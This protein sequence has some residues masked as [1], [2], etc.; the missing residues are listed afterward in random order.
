MQRQQA[1]KY[2]TD[3]EYEYFLPQVGSLMLDKC[4]QVP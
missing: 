3:I 2:K 1:D 4:V